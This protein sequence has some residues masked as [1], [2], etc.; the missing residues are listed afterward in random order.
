M[1]VCPISHVA[2]KMWTLARY[3]PLIIG[4]KIP[5]GDQHWEHYLE[6]LDILELAL[7]QVVREDTP[8]FLQV[9]IESHL[10]MF[11]S[12]YPAASIIPKMHFLVHL[13]LYL[14]Q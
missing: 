14:H 12:L 7:S 6:L 11:K 5:E 9:T 13:P 2:T 4:R 3:L 10:E 1:N 8:P